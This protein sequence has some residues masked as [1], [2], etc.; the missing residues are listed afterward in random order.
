[1]EREGTN[2]LLYAAFFFAALAGFLSTDF[3][4][5]LPAR[6]VDAVVRAISITHDSRNDIAIGGPAAKR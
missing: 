1:M 3:G 6:V 5:R 4:W 2:D